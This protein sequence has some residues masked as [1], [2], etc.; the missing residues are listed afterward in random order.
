MFSKTSISSALIYPVQWNCYY[1]VGV[2]KNYKES[3]MYVL[4]FQK[5]LGALFSGN[6][7]FQIFP[8]AFSPTKYCHKR[9][10]LHRG[11]FPRLFS[12]DCLKLQ[13]KDRTKYE[14]YLQRT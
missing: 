2:C 1:Q 3:S 5:T 7:R 11:K 10:P 12:A 13:W 8:F 14:V 9:L 6:H 4:P